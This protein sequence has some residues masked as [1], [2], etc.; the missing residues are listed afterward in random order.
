MIARMDFFSLKIDFCTVT[1]R[2]AFIGTNK[3]GNLPRTDFPIGHFFPHYFLWRY[4]NA[5]FF[6]LCTTAP[7]FMRFL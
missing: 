4:E 7:F 5:M 1:Y 3:L 6:T 2:N